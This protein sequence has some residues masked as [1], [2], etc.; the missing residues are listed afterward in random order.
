M[1]L[2]VGGNSVCGVVWYM[3]FTVKSQIGLDRFIF[4]ILFYL[5]YFIFLRSPAISLGFTTFG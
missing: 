2:A 5:F 1:D 3:S 4:F